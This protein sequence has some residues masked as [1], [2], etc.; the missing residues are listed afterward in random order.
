[1]A[2]YREARRM[3]GSHKKT[4]GGHRKAAYVVCVSLQQVA[5]LQG[6]PPDK[7]AVT[8]VTEGEVDETDRLLRR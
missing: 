7:Q 2:S 4:T 3:N 5:A 6:D 8:E 1:M